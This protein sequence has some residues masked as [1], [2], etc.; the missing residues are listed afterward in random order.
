MRGVPP[1][2]LPSTHA[3]DYS[4]YRYIYIYHVITTGNY[5][6]SRKY[7][8]LAKQFKPDMELYQQQREK[9]Q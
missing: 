8:G 6:L 3:G 1:P 2:P 5:A 9:V 4:G 7:T